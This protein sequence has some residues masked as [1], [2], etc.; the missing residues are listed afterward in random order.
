[1]TEFIGVLAR[2]PTPGLTHLLS[3][4]SHSCRC[5][6]LRSKGALVRCG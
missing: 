4:E 5:T 2:L 3:F 6:G 1:M